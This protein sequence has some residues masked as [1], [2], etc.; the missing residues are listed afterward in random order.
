MTTRSK[1][2]RPFPLPPACCMWRTAAYR[3]MATK[4]NGMM[5]T[6][7]WALVKA[8]RAVEPVEVDVATV[9]TSARPMTISRR[10]IRIL[11][12]ASER[13]KE[14]GEN[15]LSIDMKTSMVVKVEHQGDDP[16]DRKGS[17]PHPIRRG[18]N[19]DRGV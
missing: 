14:E 4:I 1:I 8:A 11:M 7:A 9:P 6:K 18:V 16:S 17:I 12:F 13:T 10:T 15:I 3:T 2:K 19:R 5:I